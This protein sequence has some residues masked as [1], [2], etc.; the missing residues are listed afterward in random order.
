VYTFSLADINP[1]SI[2]VQ[3]STNTNHN[4]W[5]KLATTASK[6]SIREVDQG[7]P[8]YPD[9]ESMGA[10]TYIEVYDLDTANHIVNA[11]KRAIGI[12]GGKPDPF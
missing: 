4:V 6:N 9:G 12:C 7:D 1:E 5:I 8:R 2:V 11:L 3:D 10:G